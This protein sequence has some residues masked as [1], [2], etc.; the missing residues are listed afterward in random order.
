MRKTITVVSAAII[1]SACSAAEPNQAMEPSAQTE[2]SV[3]KTIS[4]M[5]GQ[6]RSLDDPKN[7]LSID[8]LSAVNSYEGGPSSTARIATVSDCTAMTTD[9][10]G[11]YFTLTDVEDPSF[12][13]C[14][15]LISA[16]DNGLTFSFLPRGNTLSFER[17]K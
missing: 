12:V 5:Q 11:A 14:Y 7:T 6:W 17:M 15:Y 13:N 3:S 16:D 2:I 4:M 10:M 1:L 9:D 8:G